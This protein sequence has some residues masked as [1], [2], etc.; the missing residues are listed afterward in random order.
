[1][2]ASEYHA[3]SFFGSPDSIAQATS[4]L[5]TLFLAYSSKKAMVS[6]VQIGVNVIKILVVDSGKPALQI[7]HSNYV[8]WCILLH[9][10]GD[11]L[12]RHFFILRMLTLVWLKC[13]A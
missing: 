9:Q 11:T 2:A 6:Y 8:Y 5:E 12:R 1:M 3:E 4:E 7:H 10:L 13:S